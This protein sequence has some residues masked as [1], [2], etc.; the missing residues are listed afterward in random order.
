MPFVEGEVFKDATTQL[1]KRGGGELVHGLQEMWQSARGI[2][3]GWGEHA[4]L[5]AKTM[6]DS[7]TQATLRAGQ[8]I[9]KIQDLTHGLN[10]QEKL[11][12]FDI[13]DGTALA[14]HEK[15]DKVASGVREIY[16]SYAND[17][18]DQG[19][20]VYSGGQFQKVLKQGQ[21]QGMGYYE[22]LQNAMDQ[23]RAP[24]EAR[25]NYMPHYY[26]IKAAQ[27][28]LK[29]GPE[30]DKIIQE[31]LDRGYADSRPAAESMMRELLDRPAEFRGGPL[32]HARDQLFGEGYDRDLETV[33]RR[34]IQS[35]ARRLEQARRFGSRDEGAAD[36]IN[37]IGKTGGENAAQRV[38]TAS[39]I[40]TAWAGT[41]DP[42]LSNLANILTPIHSMTLLS[43]AG[44][45][46][47]AQLSNT[48]ARVGWKN[49]ISALAKVTSEWVR[50]EGGL[51]RWA[52]GTGAT[53]DS[54]RAD[55]QITSPRDFSQLWMKLI[56][57]E[58]LDRMN[59]VVSAVAGRFYADEL[60]RKMMNGSVDAGTARRL[61]QR[62]GLS[63]DEI[64]NRGGKLLPDELRSAGIHVSRDTQFASSVLD[65]PPLR[66]TPVGRFM[67][68]FK[69]FA[70]QQAYF[71]K[72]EL[73]DEWLKHGNIV[74]ALRYGSA[75][76]V[77]APLI[78]ESVRR[79]K[80]RR[81]PNESFFTNET[82]NL[83]TIGALGA[84]FDSGR[85]LA[86]GPEPVYRYVLGPSAGELGQF[87]GSDVKAIMTQGDVTPLVKHI[88]RRVPLVGSAIYNAWW[89]K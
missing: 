59:R 13:L 27:K 52:A 4:G 82:E 21:A 57:M 85:A 50:G 33:S 55:L 35:S 62:M 37:K 30:K 51:E 42:K 56:G 23:S 63:A 18:M 45:M 6:D 15:Y 40:Y 77:A 49:T 86:G 53:L 38:K 71:I 16:D 39:K 80:G 34:Y 84:Y 78:G 1:L 2:L 74:P 88:V 46:Q 58:H 61:F 26:G 9:G 70:L 69:S 36:L 17:A 72:R 3:N 65:L 22:A 5:L 87:L 64:Y 25:A 79:F 89:P 24:F 32:Q 68:L 10:K 48:I 81:D 12:V 83:L 66:A 14:A 7:D 44:I 41:R 67:Y 73:T 29:D 43:T 47:P 20:D 11:H 75:L 60:G 8:D 54:V 31:L 76:S 19:L 28:Y